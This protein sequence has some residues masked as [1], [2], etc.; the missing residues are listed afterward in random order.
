MA[1]THAM[2]VTLILALGIGL[3]ASAKP[4]AEAGKSCSAKSCD[5]EG[6]CET[7]ECVMLDVAGLSAPASRGMIR[8]CPG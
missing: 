2:R 5:A 1:V 3:A 7:K 6:N 4:K 8:S